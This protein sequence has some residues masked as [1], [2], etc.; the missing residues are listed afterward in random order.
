MISGI[1]NRYRRRPRRKASGSVLAGAALLLFAATG[2]AASDLVILHTNDT[3]SAIDSDA[4]G[5]GGVLPRKA[6]I[7][8]VRRAEKNVILVDAGDV[9]QGSLYFKFFGGDVEYPLM[10]MMGYDVQILGNHEFD[11]GLDSMARHYRTLEADRLSANYDFTGTSAEGIFRPWSIR[12]I[13]GRKVGFIGLNID[14]ASMIASYNYEGMGFLPVTETANRY[15][16]MLKREK[17]CDIVVAVTH[18][19]AE[20]ENDKEIDYDLARNSSNIDIII[21]G[22]SHS[23]IPPGNADPALPSIVANLDGRPVL[24]TQ[25]GK[26]GRNLGYIKVNL[27]ELDGAT[28]ADFDYRLIPV[29]D[30]FPADSYDKAMAAHIAPYKE[31]LKAVD[32][33]VVGYAARDMDNYARTGAFVNWTADFAE[34]YGRHLADSLRGAG[35][36]IPEKMDFAMMNVGGIRHSMKKGPVTEGQVLATFPFSNRLQLVAIKG[37]DFIEAMKVAAGK[38]GEAV[39]DAIRVVTDDYDNV[40]RVV[41][42]GEEMIPDKTYLMTTIDYLALGNDDFLSLAR[43]TVLWSDPLEMSA[44]V[45]QYINRLTRLGLPVEGDPRSRFVR[46]AAI[47]SAR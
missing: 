34:E 29:T 1:I 31:R 8:S 26:Y 24:V 28:P 41:V 44:R 18:I 20:R 32:T 25:T 30:R 12:E 21:G 15:A 39:S 43:G 16:D 13:D 22:H 46:E 9:V 36:D 47:P 2:A 7:D 23:L 35:M 27:D 38:H 6:L 14:P 5:R 33:H 17:G 42:N 37:S 40:V 11:N 19:G 3:H 10:N 4:E 45:L